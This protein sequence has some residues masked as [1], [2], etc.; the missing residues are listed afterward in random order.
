MHFSYDIIEKSGDVGG[1]W[2]DNTYPGVGCDVKSHLYS[3]SQLPNPA[4]SEAWSK[5]P[6]IMDYIRRISE[7]VIHKVRFNTA[8]RKAVWKGDIVNKWAVELSN[9]ET[10]MYDMIITA[11]GTLHKP[12]TPNFK[13]ME[14]YDGISFHTN[15]WNKDVDFSGK[16]VGIIGTG[17]SAV[18][19]VPRIAKMGVES[20]TVFQRTACWAPPQ[21]NFQYP[22]F[23]I[24]LFSAIP[25]LQLLYRWYLFCSN[26]IIF[27]VLFMLPS[28]NV[29]IVGHIH[30]LVQWA[31]RYWVKS[32][33]MCSVND[34][35]TAEK[36]TP[37]FPLGCK[38][39]T[40]SDLYLQ[41]FNEDHVHLCTANIEEFNRSGITTIDGQKHEL[42]VIIFATGFDIISSINAFEV[43]GLK[44]HK[45]L[46]ECHGDTPLGYYGVS[47]HVCPNFFT[48]GG[49]GIVLG[50]NTVLF[51]GE[52]QLNYIERGIESLL[53]KGAASL[54]LKAS[55]MRDYQ[56][57]ARKTSKNKVFEDA[58]HCTGWYRNDRGINWTFWPTNLVS[59][60]WNT[61]RFDSQNYHY[62]Y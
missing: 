50:H 49:P 6:E 44:G 53:E 62:T 56:V 15:R 57:W 46:A 30:S 27:F 41:S 17:A 35:I 37:K 58:K 9:G 22:R 19:A 61:L 48:I 54:R 13:G 7:S 25:I 12:K 47:H 55:A 51:V 20:L 5:G 10:V 4:W 21:G 28:K 60:W 59:F 32:H 16:R 2:L 3:Y 29:P 52:C 1:T 24:R 8:V 38:R 43:K 14:T 33:V 40:P 45:S 42:D 36:L 39:M 31:V 34:P 11:T 18:Q 26:E 23:V